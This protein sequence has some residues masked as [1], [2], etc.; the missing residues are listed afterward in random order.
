MKEE[1]GRGDRTLQELEL[2]VALEE[3]RPSDAEDIKQTLKEAND[4]LSRWEWR[5][6]KAL[7]GEDLAGKDLEELL[8]ARSRGLR[9]LTYATND[10]KMLV[11]INQDCN[12]FLDQDLPEDV[13]A[14]AEKN[15][16][17]AREL[18]ILCHRGHIERF[19]AAHVQRFDSEDTES[20]RELLR[21]ACDI[22]MQQG[23][24]RYDFSQP[25]NPLTYCSRWMQAEIKNEAE[26]GRLVRLKSRRNPLADKVERL[27]KE[28]E[29]EGRAVTVAELADKLGENPDTIAEVLPFARRATV[30]LDAPAQSD[31]PD[32]AIGDLIEDSRYQLE[33]SVAGRDMD[34]K[35][36]QA[37]D[38]LPTRYRRVVQVA[39]G[40]GDG[41]RVEQKDLFDGVYVDKS[42]QAY[43][44]KQSIIA[45]RARKGQKVKKSSQKD[46]NEKFSSGELG[47]EPGNPEAHRLAVG[48]TSS[49]ADFSKTVITCNDG[50]PPTSG[51]VQDTLRKGME[52]LAGHPA[53]GDLDLR[54][55]G[56]DEIEN[57]EKASQ[58]V[59]EA[60]MSIGAIK[61]SDLAS[62]QS[63]RSASGDKSKLRK[64]AEKHGLVDSESGRVDRQAIEDARGA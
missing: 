52:M 53:L 20:S 12:A 49:S 64:L 42:G 61:K 36:H 14:M 43:S 1:M 22:G 37:L 13:L 4:F 33:S 6:N 55:R 51:T 54:Y 24:D 11:R 29:G 62:L 44:A 45:E 5:M 48:D 40:I 46:L 31:D 19:I 58:E 17:R 3:S 7:E 9:K 2:E 59:R 21:Q 28:I 23:M 32:A 30:R 18:F 63:K 50:M 57:S 56:E 26:Q 10:Q 60:L 39:F 38:S 47:W 25:A 16:S 35:L 41:A 8:S 15:R 27:C 34:K